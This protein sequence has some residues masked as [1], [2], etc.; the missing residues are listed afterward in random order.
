MARVWGE[1]ETGCNGQD[2][3]YIQD[4]KTVVGLEGHR[5]DW[6]GC[7]GSPLQLLPFLPQAPALV[8]FKA[9]YFFRRK[10]ATS[11]FRKP[12]RW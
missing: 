7:A 4:K 12:S 5:A 9:S 2:R 6:G 11:D 3:R 1:K 10:A 8:K